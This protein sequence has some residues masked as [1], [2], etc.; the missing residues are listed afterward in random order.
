MLGSFQGYILGI[1]DRSAPNYIPDLCT[2]NR[3]EM[4]AW[5]GLLLTCMRLY[6]LNTAHNK[7]WYFYNKKLPF[8]AFTV[9]LWNQYGND[10]Y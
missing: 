3:M 10:I 2:I 7:S 8:Y 6:K 5:T 9:L 1:S 4:G